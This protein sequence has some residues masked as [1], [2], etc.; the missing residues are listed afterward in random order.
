VKNMATGEQVKL[1]P[2]AAA[3]HIKATLSA[4]NGP[5]ILEG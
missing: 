5:V 3:A 4:I 2:A 1:A